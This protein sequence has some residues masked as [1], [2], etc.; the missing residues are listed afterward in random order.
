MGQTQAT[1]EA[2]WPRDLLKELDNPSSKDPSLDS[3]SH[4]DA[5]IYALKTVI[6]HYVNQGA[7]ALIKNPQ[8]HASTKHIDT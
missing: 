5:T 2:I 3:I 8:C 1:K 7:I 4:D 6:I